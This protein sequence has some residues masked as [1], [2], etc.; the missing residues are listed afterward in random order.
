MP[1]PLLPPLLAGDRAPAPR[2]L[3]EVVREV[4]A[5]W[6]DEPAVDSGVAV[7]TYAELVEAADALADELAGL[8]AGPG[9]KVAVRVRSGT[10]DLYVAVLG[11]LWSGAAYVPID[12]DDP[13]ERAR[14]VI[15]ESGAVAVVGND[16]ALTP[17][18]E[19]PARERR[20]PT[21]QDDAWVIFTSGSTGTPKGVAVTHRS[22]AAFVDA[23]ARLFLQ[24]APIGPG[25]RVM[26]GLSVAFD[27]SCEEMWLAWAY[28]ACLV[29]APRSLVRSGVDVGPWL[30][31]NDITVVSTV[32][33]LVSLWPASSLARVRLLIMGGEACPPEL[34][35]RL[36]EPGREVWNTYGPTEATVVACAA[37]LDGSDPVRIGLPLAGWDLAVVD[38][39]GDPVAEGE[40]GE[41]IIGGV[42]LARYL[43][44][45][46]DAQAYAPMPSLGWDRAYRSGD[47][48]RNDPDGLV[49]GGRADDQVKV[50]GRRIELGELDDQLLRLPGVVSAAAAVRA[51]RSG[52]KLLLGYLT[53]DESYDAGAAADLLRERLPAALVPRLAV[54]DDMPTR[55][56]GKVDRDALPWPLPGAA[57]S[58]GSGGG[59]AGG[60]TDGGLDPTQAWLAQIW[61][62]VLGAE[63]AG[64]QDDFFAYGGGSLTAAQVVSRIREQY[65]EVV[66]GDVYEHPTIGGL[67]AA[68]PRTSTG[69]T[70]TDR[71]VV[72]L[73]RKTQVG[74]L[75]AFLPL[76]ALAGM[77]WLTWLMLGSTLAHGVLDLAWLPTYP[78]WALVVL[79]WFFLVP[80]GRMTLAALLARGVLR[81]VTAGE[82]PRGGKVHLR[83]WLAERIQDELAATSLA[84]APWFPAYARLLGNRVG[85]GVDLHTLPSVTG[86]LTVGDGAAIEPEVDLAG[87]WIDGDVLHVGPVTVRARAR[88]GAR[89]TL[90]PGA[91]VGKD[92]EVAPG[93]YVDG[94]VPAG[95]YWSGAPAE[96]Q[97]DRARGPWTGE[98]SSGDGVWLGAYGALA[99]LIAALPAVAIACGALV[100]LPAVRD[101]GSLGDAV[102]SSWPWLPAATLVGYAVLALLVLVLVRALGAGMQEGHVPVRS[103]TGVRIWGTL[104]VL[105][106]ARTWLFPLYSSALTPSWLRLLGARVGTGVEA[107]TVLL[108]PRFTTIGDHA[109]LADDTL[110]GSYELG[111]G[112]MRVAHVKIGKRAFVGNSGM[113]APGRKVPK[114]SLVAVLSA[115]PSRGEARAR[116]SWVGSPPTRLRR[117]A[118]G[119]D[120]SRTYDPP[121]GL[122][123]ARGAV[124]LMRV[125]PMLVLAFLVVGVAVSL[126]WLLQQGLW[127]AVLLAGPV[128]LLAG[129][130]AAAVATLAKWVLVGRHAVGDHPLWSSFVWRN[131]LADTFTEVVAAPWFAAPAQ[132]T[133]ALNVWLRSMG[134]RIGRGVWVDSYW[135]PETDLVRLDDGA[136]VNRGCVVQTH[137]FHDRVLSMDEVVLRAGATLGPNSVILP[138]ASIGKHTTVGP[139]SLVMRGEAVPARTC[140]IGNPIGPWEV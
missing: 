86:L 41:L 110:V 139:V 93:S 100:L 82:H 122:R 47:V 101:A 103:G 7:L 98:A 137:L 125:V 59:G 136:T 55:T 116:S 72:P 32:P 124:E 109:F 63:V 85:A 56:S 13:D 102:A 43:D 129:V 140:W 96:R 26:A 81:G 108:I 23:E 17:T 71:D 69:A 61:S 87:H 79:G 45:E 114:E 29:P 97:S 10:T 3:V 21:P 8:G 60:S 89:C 65:P 16:L 40:S 35:A 73:R 128:L 2:T 138:A 38:A 132:G 104:R 20:D 42:G 25:D 58:G 78:A 84:G 15:A 24:D 120:D 123:V 113:A 106:E 83:I 107:S 34:A 66:V 99:W 94:V 22:A 88:V 48:V 80:P 76:R 27:A 74:Q 11:V 68:L 49:F 70:Q 50:G 5:Y 51:T 130:V 133:V 6:P 127:P 30:V 31:A 134:A 19:R 111:G 131:E 33:T 90:A 126:G 39:H 118:A 18:G 95:E 115:A 67:A 75:L 121:T 37:L 52:N 54:V 119:G 1:H 12:A 46:K 92:A 14:V 62:D 4:A 64:P 135:L 91:V 105:D 53:V 44:A 9:A 112:W 117:A 36:E 57:S 28:G 77:R